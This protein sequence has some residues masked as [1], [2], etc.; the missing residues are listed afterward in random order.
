MYTSNLKLYHF[1]FGILG[2]FHLKM[3]VVTENVTVLLNCFQF[4]MG[5]GICCVFKYVCINKTNVKFNVMSATIQCLGQVYHHLFS[6]NVQL[7]FKRL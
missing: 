7:Q 3:L 4:D 1:D 5:I 2:E 6:N